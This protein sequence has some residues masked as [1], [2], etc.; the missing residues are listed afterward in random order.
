MRWSRTLLILLLATTLSANDVSYRSLQ[1]GSATGPTPLHDRGIRGEGQIIALLD[2]GVDYDSCYFAE[3]D[4]RPPPINT[5]SPRDGLAFSNVDL[6]RRKIVAYNFL[7][8]CDQFPGDPNCED[9]RSVFAYDNLGHGTKAAGAAVGDSGTPLLHD[10]GDA[11]APGAKLIVQ[12]TGFVSTSLCTLPGLGCPPTDLRPLLDQ[13]YKQGARISSQSWG[14]VEAAYTSRARDLDDFVWRNPDLLVIFNAGN[15]GQNGTSTVS[16]P[17]VAKNVLQVGGTRYFDENDDVIPSYSGLGPTTDGRIKPDLVAPSYVRSADGDAT[18][19]SRNCSATQSGG[20]SWSAPTL[21]GAAALV[22]QYYTEGFY[23]YGVKTETQ[24]RIPS[25]ALLKATLIAAARR[26]SFRESN[27]NLVPTSEVPSVEQGFGFPVLDDALYF[28]GD[29]DR[30]S[31][32]DVP[33]SGGLPAGEA[34]VFSFR[35]AAGAKLEFVLVWTDP[36]GSASGNA[37]PQ[38]V[39]DLDLEVLD[40]SGAITRGNATFSNDPDRLNNVEAVSLRAPVSGIYRVT[41]RA[42]RLGLGPRQGFA[43][44]ATGDFQ[45]RQRAARRRR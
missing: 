32:L 42:H 25:A 13:I 39:N 36:P 6:S 3:P 21:A 18:V 31:M 10:P 37:L 45:V 9:P 34:K 44:V 1:S 2:T 30:L 20:T 17:G 35:A 23:P 38:L 8:S 11:I 7:F 33:T 29:R 14:D 28:S 4:R 22:R 19:D 26:V 16:S 24:R 41:V 15:R 5:G 27:G 12:D 43:F 40:P